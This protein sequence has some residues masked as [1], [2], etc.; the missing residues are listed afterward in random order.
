MKIYLKCTFKVL[1]FDR[2][3]FNIMSYHQ[4][5]FISFQKKSKK[6]EPTFYATT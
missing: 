6:Y 5:L 4:I 1:N 2:I 3:F